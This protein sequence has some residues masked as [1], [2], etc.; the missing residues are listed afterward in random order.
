VRLTDGTRIFS[1][2]LGELGGAVH[3]GAGLD[4]GGRRES[5]GRGLGGKKRGREGM[6]NWCRGGG[7]RRRGRGHGDVREVERNGARDGVRERR[8]IVLYGEGVVHG[9][10]VGGKKEEN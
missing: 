7:G 6:N 2:I 9:G 1:R 10:G 4:D 3:D 5:G 8:A